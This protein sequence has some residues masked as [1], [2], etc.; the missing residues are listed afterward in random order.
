MGERLKTG[1]RRWTRTASARTP[2]S[3]NVNIAP[4]GDADDG[5]RSCINFRRQGRP[6]EG[7]PDP[8]SRARSAM[9]ISNRATSC[10]HTTLFGDSFVKRSINGPPLAQRIECLRLLARFPERTR[11][12]AIPHRQIALPASIAGI[13]LR[14]RRRREKRLLVIHGGP[15]AFPKPAIPP[16]SASR[17]LRR[18]GPQ[19]GR[20]AV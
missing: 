15:R 16:R 2:Q 1:C 10:F 8:L 12:A 11:E 9:S 6:M 19:W 3:S 14:H 20:H 18:R 17:S 7:G 5:C 4:V 13:G